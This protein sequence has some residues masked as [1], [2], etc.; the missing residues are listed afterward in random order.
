MVADSG[1]IIPQELEEHLFEPFARGDASRRSNGGSGLGLS[2]AQ[3]VVQMHGWEMRLV[4]Q[5]NIQHYPY[6]ERYAKAFQIRIK[7]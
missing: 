6:V 2:I 3:K 5:P 7:D 1:T 4:Q